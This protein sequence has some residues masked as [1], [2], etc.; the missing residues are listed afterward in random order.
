MR[1]LGLKADASVMLRCA[2]YNLTIAISL[3]EPAG[4]AM[5]RQRTRTTAR[6]T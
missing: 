2:N 3:E 6:A 5:P 1:S 4:G